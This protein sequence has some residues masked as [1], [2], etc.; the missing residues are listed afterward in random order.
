MARRSRRRV[1]GVGWTDRTAHC[2]TTAHVRHVTY[3][4]SIPYTSRHRAS[5]ASCAECLRGRTKIIKHSTDKLRLNRSSV[6][7]KQLRAMWR[8]KTLISVGWCSSI[9]TV[10]ISK[11]TENMKE[12]A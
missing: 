12:K 11:E 7:I 5:T 4:S 1:R 6:S 10:H 2:F 3:V 8:N 9:T